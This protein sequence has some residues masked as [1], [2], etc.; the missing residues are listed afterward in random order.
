MHDI[1]WILSALFLLPGDSLPT[2]QESGKQPGKFKL[3]YLL[4]F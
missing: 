2:K 3:D 1:G 4:F